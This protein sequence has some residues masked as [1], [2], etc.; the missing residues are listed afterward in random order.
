[1]SKATAGTLEK[2]SEEFE[3]ELLAELREG[4][5]QALSTVESYR[6]EAKV[7]VTRILESSV[8]QG[9]SLRRQIIG[10]AELEARNAQL[11]ALEK[12]VVEVFD[13][14]VKE[15]RDGSG[16]RYE[17]SLTQLVKEGLEM[18]G[19]RARIFCRSKDG[20]TVS[21]ALRRLGGSQ[22]KLVLEEKGIG[23]SGGVV[24]TSMDGSMRFDNTFEA[25]L[26]RMRPIL[27]MEASAILTSG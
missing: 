20:S 5:E 24:M 23:T 26:E 3:T 2:V 17:A 19:P 12:A 6:R 14:A 27:R 18:I 22:S 7:A 10:A 15:L 13:A 8:K 1:M 25:R 16:A 21:A 4:K 9:E 11:K